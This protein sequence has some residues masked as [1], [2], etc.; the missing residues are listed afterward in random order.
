MTAG[1]ESL[2]QPP[3]PRA[4]TTTRSSAPT[5]RYLGVLYLQSTSAHQF[6]T[7]CVLGI[8]NAPNCFPPSRTARPPNQESP[9]AKAAPL[10]SDCRHFK[11][12][13]QSSF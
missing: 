12:L 8:T 2:L 10:A 1:S 11:A 9:L 13:Q 3:P 5:P 4:F 7:D 6:A